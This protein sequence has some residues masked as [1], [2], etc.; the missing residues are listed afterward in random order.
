VP[1]QVLARCEQRFYAGLVPQVEQRGVS[2]DAAGKPVTR[3]SR[4]N[5]DQTGLASTIGA[6][7]LQQ[8]TGKDLERERGKQL[9]ASALQ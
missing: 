5:A 6:L 4:E 1:G 2:G 8:M 9:P 7:D 3:Q